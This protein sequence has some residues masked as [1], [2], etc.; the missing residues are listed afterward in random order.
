MVATAVDMLLIV[1]SALSPDEQDDAFRRIADKR[2]ERLAGDEADSSRY[3]R[4]LQRV[5]EV[6]GGPPSAEQYR[7]V[8]KQLVQA[9][10]AVEPLHRIRAHFVTWEQAKE[11]LGLSET[12][13]AAAIQ[14]RFRHR[15][16]GKVRRYTDQTLRD[17]LKRAAEECTTDGSGPG[18]LEY[19]WWRNRELELGR[20]RGDA[21]LQIPSA[22]AFRRRWGTW[23]GTL[24]ANG[25]TLEE[26]EE[27]LDRKSATRR[28]SWDST[29]SKPRP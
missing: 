26:A 18:Q 23:E 19:D 8:Q 14:A 2:T 3:V 27:R 15:R 4:S 20:A 10:E 25:Y 9:G 24:L 16:I 6:V 1:F 7:L 11:A 22:A 17:A 13:T 29:R 28:E 12:T 21:M 5:A